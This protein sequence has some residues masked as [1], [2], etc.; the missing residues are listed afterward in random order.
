MIRLASLV[1]AAVLAAS[2]APVPSDGQAMTKLNVGYPP[3]NDFVPA[4]LAKDQGFFEKHGLDVTLTPQRVVSNIP[5][6]LTSGALDLGALPPAVILGT[7]EGALDLVAFECISRNTRKN[8]VISLIA[9]KNSPIHAASDLQGKKV[10][11]PGLYGGIDLMLR[12]WLLERKV[13]LS[14]VTFVEVPLPAMGDLLARNQVDAVTAIEPV[15][16]RILSSPNASK[17]SDYVG[18][19]VEDVCLITWG[20]TRAWAK[21]HGDTL[22]RFNAALA[23]GQ[24]FMQ[25]HPDQAEAV[26][27]KYLGFS[28]PSATRSAKLTADDFLFY[29]NTMRAVG[30]LKNPI[31]FSTLIYRPS[32]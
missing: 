28:G 2:I 31:D 27:K 20:S 23:D 6:A 18:D 22:A 29:A 30:L 12:A 19:L 11:V 4:F 25:S 3:A 16:S 24:R 7:R 10:G 9:N 32:K 26:Q 21:T 1:L 14:S 15:R 17:V 8:Q 13:P 5:V